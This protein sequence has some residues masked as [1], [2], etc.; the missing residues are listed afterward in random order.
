MSLGHNFFLKA[1]QMT[2]KYSQDEN[3]NLKACEVAVTLS[4]WQFL[5]HQAIMLGISKMR[6]IGLFQVLTL[7]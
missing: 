6:R 5:A 7:L 3:H 4:Y 2:M 1:P